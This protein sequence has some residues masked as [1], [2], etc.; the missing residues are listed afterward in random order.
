MG[1]GAG[2]LLSREDPGW[3]KEIKVKGGSQAALV[4]HWGTREGPDS[5]IA[6]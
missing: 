1:W 2:G 4:R 3:A 6:P 5:T